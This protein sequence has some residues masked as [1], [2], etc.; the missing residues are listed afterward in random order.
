M[1]PRL[2]ALLFIFALL[3]ALDYIT[4]IYGVEKGIFVLLLLLS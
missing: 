2:S 1:R 4:T 3:N